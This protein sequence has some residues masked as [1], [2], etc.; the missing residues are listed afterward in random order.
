MGDGQGNRPEL[1]L[2]L[3]SKDEG[4]L[5]EQDVTALTINPG[6]KHRLDQ[7]VAV[8]KSH[9]FHRL[10]GFGVHRFGRGEH[11]GGQDMPAD[12]LMQLGAGAGPKALKGLGVK[13]HRMGIGDETQNVIFLSPPAL[14]GV[15]L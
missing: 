14:D 11:P 15:F 3:S 9:E 6:E 2:D 12:M 1:L 5:I 7:A 8:V 13:L 4:S 10:V